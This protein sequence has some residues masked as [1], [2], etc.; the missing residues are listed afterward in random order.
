[1]KIKDYMKGVKISDEDMN[2]MSRGEIKEKVRE[3]NTERWKD[4]ISKKPKDSLY[5][6]Y[7]GE[8]REEKIYDNTYALELLFGARANSLDLTTSTPD[9]GS[10]G[11]QYQIGA[12]TT[13]AL[14]IRAP[15]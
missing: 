15:Q 9:L 6:E 14:V 3:R 13:T 4:E 11:T 12:V 8:I 7:K 5:K 1:M 10:A 2:E